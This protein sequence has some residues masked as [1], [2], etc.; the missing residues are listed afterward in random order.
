MSNPTIKIVDVSTGEEVEREMTDEEATN[1][2][3]VRQSAL[4]Q[5]AVEE[6]QEQA[7]QTALDKLRAI[8]LTDEEIAAL[9]GA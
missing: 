6:A 8:G 1:F 9:V 5:K 3:L 2:E 4:Q 7:R